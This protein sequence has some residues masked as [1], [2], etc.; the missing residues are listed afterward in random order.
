MARATKRD[1]AKH[2]DSTLLLTVAE[3]AALVGVSRVTLWKWSRRG[4]FPRP[5][6]IGG[7]ANGRRRFLRREVI[8]WVEALPPAPGG[9]TEASA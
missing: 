7:N 8:A 2:D 9:P 5:R 1:A 3:A 6:V 4:A